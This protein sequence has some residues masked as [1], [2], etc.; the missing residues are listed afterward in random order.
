L[1]SIKHRRKSEDKIHAISSGRRDTLSFINNAPDEIIAEARKCIIQAGKKGGY[2]LGSG[3]V[4]PRDA[5]RENV[6]ALRIASERYGI[7]E[8][9]KLSILR[10]HED[11]G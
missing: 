7:Y 2:I 8:N 11:L 10:D 9:G 4:V 5:K 1:E 3:C 6:E